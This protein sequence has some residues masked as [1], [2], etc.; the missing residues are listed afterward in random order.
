MQK[1]DP[2]E[3]MRELIEEVLDGPRDEAVKFI[4]TFLQVLNEHLLELEER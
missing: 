2:Y 4:E 1:D 3:R